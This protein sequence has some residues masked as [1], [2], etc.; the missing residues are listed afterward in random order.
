MQ[1]LTSCGLRLP[2]SDPTLGGENGATLRPYPWE[3]GWWGWPTSG[4]GPFML[5]SC[6]SKASTDNNACRHFGSSIALGVI[7][8]PVLSVVDVVA[9]LR[10]P[11]RQPSPYY[12]W[13][14]SLRCSSSFLPAKNGDQCLVSVVFYTRRIR[15]SSVLPSATV[16]CGGLGIAGPVER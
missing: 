4:L 14:W 2:K 3:G 7:P 1:K 13:R 10:L 11:H 5:L 15:R 12:H 8:V 9:S 16:E 6:R